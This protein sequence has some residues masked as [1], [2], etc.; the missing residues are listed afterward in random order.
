[1]LSE[2]FRFE[3]RYQIR[4]PLFYICFVVFFLL[5]FGAITT[6]SV[7]IGGAIGNVNRNAPY[8]IMQILLVMSAIGVFSTTAFVGTSVHRDFEYNTHALFFTSP[9][10]KRDYFFGRFLG[11]FT[12]AYLLFFSVVLA[13]IVGSR[14]PWLEAE[15]IGPFAKM[16]YLFSMAVL[17]LP[18][19]FLM[20]AIFFSLAAL[21][22]SMLYTY[23]GVAVFFVGYAVAGRFLGDLKNEA[24]ASLLDPFGFGSF[25]LA[26]R[27][28][29]VY[30][31]NAGVIPLHG[32]LL[33]NRLLWL[34]VALVVLLIG[35][36]RF[37]FV[38]THEG[39]KARKKRLREE[40]TIG[41]DAAATPIRTVAVTPSFSGPASLRQLLYQTRLELNGM[42]R[43][44]PFLVILLFG[45]LNVVGGA[46]QADRLFGT[47]VWPVTNL[48]IS[49]IE[50]SF[51]LFVLII[52]TFYAGELV[53][54]ERSVKLNEV[55][56]A[57][58][59]RTFVFWSAKLVALIAAVFALLLVAMVTT[60]AVQAA[61][62]YHFFEPLLYL[63]GI[64]L[65][66]G[67]QFVLLAVLALFFQVATNNRYV[68][69]LLMT[70]YFVS[71]FA[72]PALHFQHHLY[73]YGTTPDAPY[74]DM[75]GY[76]HF[77]R[78]MIWFT[79]YWSCF[80]VLLVLA[81]HLFWVRGTESAARTRLILARQ[82]FGRGAAAVALL[83]LIALAGCG[84]Y[85]FYNTNILNH[86]ATDEERDTLSAE[87]EKL[88]RKYNRL[89]Q[90]RIMAVQSDV[91][92]D[93]QRRFVSIRGTYGLTNRTAI[94]IP[95]VNVV[96]DPQRKI[97]S[98]ALVDPISGRSMVRKLA[99]SDP[100][101]GYYIYELS[102]PLQ[103]GQSLRLQFRIEDRNPGFVNDNSNTEVVYNGTFFNSATHF[104]H[105]GY[106]PF[107]EL[108]DRNKRKKNGL[109]PVE[110]LP[111]ITDVAA[112]GNSEIS[113]EAD[114]ITYDTTVSTTP[115]QI[116]IA[117][118]YLQREWTANSKRYF[119]Y[120][121]DSPILDFFA[122]MSAD[123][124]IRRDRWKGVTIEV[125]YD[126][127][128]P[129]NVARMID[130]VKKSLDYF[131]VNFGPYQHHQV[132]IIEFPRYAR[133]AQSFPNTIPFSESIGFITRVKSDEDIDYV[134][135]VTAHE[136][137]HQWWAHQAI[138]ANVQGATMLTETLAQYSAL[139]VMEK[140][141]G[142]Q[143]MR[144]FLRYELNRYLAGR[145]GELVGEMPLMLVENQQYIHYAKGSL[146]MYALRDAIGE[147]PLNKA[148]AGYLDQYKFKG[149]PYPTT[150]DFVNYVQQNTPLAQR[151]LLDDLFRRITLYENRAAEVSST[152]RAD[153]KYDVKV[154]VEAKK[155][156]S[157]DRGRETAMPMHESVDIGV[158]G[159]EGPKKKETVLFFQKRPITGAKQT[160]EMVVSGKPVKAGIDPYN[161]LI[162]RNPDDNV[163][164]F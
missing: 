52:L 141:F 154:T 93:P 95:A 101:H 127:K 102:S 115:G 124:A 63:K 143:T 108:E 118:G 17:V 137:A 134:F 84:G 89:P 158:F 104:P 121:M 106:Q 21:T 50:G 135:Y 136:V 72:L 8:V 27:Y 76:G 10:R 1:M 159:E 147:A 34:A 125:Y 99:L 31:K 37:R 96:M 33:Y 7:Q 163:K 82:R 138:G 30:E 25:S 142:Q 161:K 146:V 55:Y 13:I 139:M 151:P 74:S 65:V 54:R 78:P 41:A 20:G 28:W 73:I 109:G 23:A 111:K 3:V 18:N 77:V 70:L 66:I 91:D 86:Y 68:G 26:T 100:R 79:L 44:I 107:S 29:T 64:F 105:I 43:S 164:K 57:L 22:R 36:N 16:P 88:Y 32:P 40:S 140:E 83:A 132:R 47:R 75:N 46:T 149:P 56:D 39:R 120:R 80:A 6:D 98:M 35:F 117:P 53:F 119:H 152:R 60:I 130:G 58:P 38:A 42:F 162:D 62:G 9:I 144:K 81:V 122:Y 19:V 92:I 85:I 156:Y 87:F 148:I 15:R 128:H 116:A 112:Y 51:L 103:P 69:F 126:R 11:S 4:Q 49:A 157:D 110:R 150:I 97:I 14:M 131:T 133:F 94:A 114:W 155:F 2:I 129:F 90:P 59:A 48:M 45:V 24:L 113:N 123:W 61:N 67:S 12:V 71:L 153:G 5:T 160:F 145:G